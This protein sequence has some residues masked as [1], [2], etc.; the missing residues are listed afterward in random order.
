MTEDVSVEKSLF[1]PA[2]LMVANILVAVLPQGAASAL[3]RDPGCATLPS[4]TSFALAW[5]PDSHKDCPTVRQGSDED[6]GVC[7]LEDKSPAAVA[8]PPVFRH[9]FDA[10]G[11]PTE[12]ERSR[13]LLPQCSGRSNSA[14]APPTLANG[15]P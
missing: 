8:T 4:G 11:Y 9:C 10:K 3:P 12:P 1:D 5:L 14:R 13:P 6:L 2:V 15:Q 7:T